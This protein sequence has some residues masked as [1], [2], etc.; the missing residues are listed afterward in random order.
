MP[1]YILVPLVLV[2]L[3]VVAL[4]AGSMIDRNHKAT[5]TIELRATPAQVWTALTDWRQFQTWRKDLKAVVA[6]TAPD[7]K[8]GWVETSK[9][10]RMPLVTEQAEAERL[11]VT[12][13]ADDTLPFGGTWTHRLEALP[14]GGT[15]L[16]ST[17]DGFVKPAFFRL[18]AKVV[19][20]YHK[21]LN[22]YQRALAN[23]FGESVTPTNS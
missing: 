19:F 16:S 2:G 9:W 11:F 23:K 5:S 12:R 15:R 18:M 8:P 20:G 14:G 13:I 22:D 4:L 1:W 7:G 3:I 17:E 10:G 6:F 21:T